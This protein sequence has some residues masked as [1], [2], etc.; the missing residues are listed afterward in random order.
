MGNMRTRGST[1]RGMPPGKDIDGYLASVPAPERAVLEKL[2]RTIR[3]AAPGAEEKIAYGMPAFYDPG[4]LV[5]FAA[6]KDHCSFF[7]MSVATMEKFKRE[8]QGYDRTRGSIHF[9]AA[10]PLPAALVRK[11]V[12]AR[13]GENAERARLRKGR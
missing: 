13:I 11:I 2:R 10:R 4:P 9:T 6:F 8:L 12:K 5:A 1:I 7:P 3:A